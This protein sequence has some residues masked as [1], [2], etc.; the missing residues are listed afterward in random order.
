MNDAG[1]DEA[2]APVEALPGD[3]DAKL[4]LSSETTAPGGTIEAVVSLTSKRVV[5]VL[6]TL[7]YGPKLSVTDTKGI[8]VTEPV[9]PEPPRSK[10]YSCLAAANPCRED[11]SASALTVDPVSPSEVRLEWTARRKVWRRVLCCPRPVD[12][13]V[14]PRGTYHL[15]VRFPH[16]DSADLV[17]EHDVRVE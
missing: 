8:D 14:L 17:L 3:L 13:A 9:G 1:G 4:S 16:P 15:T 12:A 2:A 7:L 5:P 6:F 11:P 10:S